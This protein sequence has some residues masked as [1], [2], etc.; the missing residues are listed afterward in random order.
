MT[1]HWKG[2]EEHFDGTISFS[3]QPFFGEKNPFSESFSKTPH[4]LKS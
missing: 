1:I 2:L 3:I 4:S